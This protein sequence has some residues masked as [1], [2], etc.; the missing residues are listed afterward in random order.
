LESRRYIITGG[1]GSGKSTLLVALEAAGHCCYPEVSRELIRE[2]SA[3]QN[4]VLPWSNLPAFANLAFH[5][6][7][8]QHDHAL[9]AGEFCFFDRGV[10]DIFGY[11]QHGGYRVPEHYHEAH[12][13]CR[14]ERDVFMLPPWP[15]IYVNDLERPQSYGESVALYEALCQVYLSLGYR[16]HE[17][18][19]ASVEKRREY[20]FS[21]T[22]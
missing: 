13:G 1:P 12:G 18:P 6:M 2:Q 14:Y 11:L 7:M 22:G 20:L 8:Q 3:L 9:S 19:K 17:V 21:V 4:G 10:P 5:A 16:L 15:E